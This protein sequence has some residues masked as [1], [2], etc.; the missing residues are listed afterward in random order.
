METSAAIV[1]NDLVIA[2]D[3]DN[4][5]AL[6]LLDLSS[7]FNTVNCQIL[8]SVLQQRFGLEDEVLE[9]W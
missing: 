5:S 3:A 6:V 2:A 4:V 8:Q 1:H 9:W 7:A